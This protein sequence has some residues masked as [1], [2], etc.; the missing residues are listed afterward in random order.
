MTG[1]LEI[2]KGERGYVAI[3]EKSF[4]TGVYEDLD[5][6]CLALDSDRN[7]AVSDSELIKFDELADCL[8]RDG[9]GSWV[10]VTCGDKRVALSDAY[11]L[12]EAASVAA[13]RLSYSGPVTVRGYNFT[14]AFTVYISVEDL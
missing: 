4:V 11:D 14:R 9:M 3:S 1:K 7:I 5:T 10:V 6:L 2:F 12:R 13:N 8:F